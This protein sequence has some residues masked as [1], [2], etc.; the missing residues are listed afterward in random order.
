[1]RRPMLMMPLPLK[2]AIASKVHGWPCSVQP[3]GVELLARGHSFVGLF[4][5]TGFVSAGRSDARSCAAASSDYTYP[6]DP[7]RTWGEGHDATRG[8]PQKPRRD[9]ACRDDLGV[10]AEHAFGC[11]RLGY[12][13]A[14]LDPVDCR[15][16]W[17]R[18]IRG[19]RPLARGLGG[20]RRPMPE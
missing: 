20:S 6:K 5:C 10:R 14:D 19:G 8:R 17:K 2:L 12:A 13:S 16:R 9:R 1:M 11:S 18:S 15:P 7:K 4:Y 3:L